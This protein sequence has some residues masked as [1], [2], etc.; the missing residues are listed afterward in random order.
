MPETVTLSRSIPK[1]R[2]GSAAEPSPASTDTAVAH[3]TPAASR[4]IPAVV[5][6][7]TC[8]PRSRRRLT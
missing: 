4:R 2:S 3:T 1:D 6:S 5:F 7:I 8:F